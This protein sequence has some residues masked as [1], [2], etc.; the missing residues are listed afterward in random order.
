M[1]LDNDEIVDVEIVIVLG[2]GD[3]RFQALAHVAGDTLAREFEIGE[4]GRNLLAADELRQEVELLRADPQHA[5]NRLGL[6]VGE[7]ALALFLAHAKT[8]P[9]LTTR[10]RQA[11]PA[12][13]A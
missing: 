8:S 1:S 2:V 9:R 7:R 5:G 4:R 6:G 3:R 10:R 13:R 11:V 12:R